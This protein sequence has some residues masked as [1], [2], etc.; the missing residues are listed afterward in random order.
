MFQA[1][2]GYYPD[3]GTRTNF[4]VLR[5]ADQFYV[6]IEGPHLSPGA[7]A[8]IAC[9][10]IAIT[11]IFGLVIYFAVRRS[12]RAAAHNDETEALARSDE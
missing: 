8:G 6:P 11:G 7:I 10:A 3:S 5:R 9:A 12:R 2:Y 1:S 4:T